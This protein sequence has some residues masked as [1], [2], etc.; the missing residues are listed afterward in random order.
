MNDPYPASEFDDWAPQYDH[1]V[2]TAGFPFA[3]YEHT[4]KEIVRSAAPQAE[5]RVLDLGAGTGNLSALFLD[6]GCS[7]T[8]LDYSAEMLKIA[9][10]KHPQAAYLQ[11]DLRSAPASYLPQQSFERIVSAYSF[12]HFPLAEK[13]RILQAFLPSLAPGGRFVI[14]DIAFADAAAKK[15]A[16]VAAGAEWDEEEYWLADEALGVLARQQFNGTFLPTSFCAGVF[17]I[18]PRA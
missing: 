8:A 5:M 3:G 12:H 6:A 9:R 1:D 7:V 11:A 2:R 14:G 18:T 10:A 16:R 15:A 4:L 17:T 13:C